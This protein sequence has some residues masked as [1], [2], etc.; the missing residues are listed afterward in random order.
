M[1]EDV[2]IKFDPKN[3]GARDKILNVTLKTRSENYV[4]LPT[5][6]KGQGL[7]SRREIIRGIY[8]AE[9]LT[10]EIEGVCITNIVNT[11]EEDVTIDTPLVELE[12]I[13]EPVQSEVLIF[14][15]TLVEDEIRLS[16][17]CK[18]LRTDHLSGEER[19]SSIRIC[20]EYNYVFPLPG[21]KLT[22]TTVAEHAIHSPIIDPIRG[23]DYKTYRIPE[24][25]KEEVNRQT[26][27]IL[28][29]YIIVPSTSPWN[30]PILI[31]PKKADVSGVKK[32]RIV[33]D[34]RRLIDVTVGDSFPIPV[35]S[36]V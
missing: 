18:E 13:E 22:F 5:T 27:Q 25:H 29:D 11:L 33:V 35:L 20:E 6:C 23:I 10:R 9:S 32:W 15:T 8:M 3:S 19:V 31:V 30:S 7:I 34:F 26:E 1:E 12:E 24:I 16:K 36:E 4:K 17:L 2:I 14:V 28:R 21:D